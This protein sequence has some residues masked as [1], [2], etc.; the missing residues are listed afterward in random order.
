VE[1]RLA[2]SVNRG[3]S[4]VQ[5]FE[6]AWA[7]CVHGTLPTPGWAVGR[8]LA[9]YQPRRFPVQGSWPRRVPFWRKWL[10]VGMFDCLSQSGELAGGPSLH[11]Q[12]E[13]GYG[14]VGEGSPGGGCTEMCKHTSCTGLDLQTPGDAAAGDRDVSPGDPAGQLR[15][16]VSPLGDDPTN[17]DPWLV[18]RPQ[19]DGF[20]HHFGAG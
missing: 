16:S 12:P 2:S 15:L 3:T 11:G 7:S 14:E 4:E 8:G 20:R 10:G 17:G 1:A 5:I 18:V 6:P 13:Q 19:P 9:V